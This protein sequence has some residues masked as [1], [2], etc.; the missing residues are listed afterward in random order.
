M[1]FSVCGIKFGEIYNKEM[2]LMFCKMIIEKNILK[3]WIIALQKLSEKLC[4][5]IIHLYKDV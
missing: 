1:H 2:F 3:I 4:F 5:M